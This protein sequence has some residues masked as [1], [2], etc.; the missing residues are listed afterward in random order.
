MPLLRRTLLCVPLLALAACQPGKIDNREIV[1]RH[2]T[3]V[4]ASD[5][6]NPPFAGMD[7]RNG[8]WG[9][10]VEMMERISERIRRRIEW[11]QMPFEELLDAVVD[12]RADI[13]CATMG[14]TPERSERVDFS[15]PYYRTGIGVVVRA[16][17]DEPE[18][19]TDLVGKRVGASPGTTSERAVRRKLRLSR[20][21]FET[22]GERSVR[23]RLESGEADA[24]VM[25]GPEAD[26]VV[27]ESDGALR[28]LEEDLDFELYAL[29]VR[30]RRVVLL[31][32]L[33]AAIREMNQNGE[34]RELDEQYGTAS[35]PRPL[36]R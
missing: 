33:D 20:H 24:W 5:L 7:P 2:G 3:L 35:P 16:G 29:A 10:D 27:L 4:I 8:P 26:R 12:G 6:A 21:L 13:V 9:R 19:L 18:T 30:R 34:M 22:T 28:R 23:E 25:D 32:Q 1:A 11:K 31:D 17:E 36:G 15:R 14:I